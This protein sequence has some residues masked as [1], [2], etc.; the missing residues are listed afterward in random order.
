MFGQKK[1]PYLTKERKTALRE[2]ARYLKANFGGLTAL[3]VMHIHADDMLALLDELQELN[4]SLNR[5]E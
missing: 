1:K 4:R 2:D 3:A 5:P